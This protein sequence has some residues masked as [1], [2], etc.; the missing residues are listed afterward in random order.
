MPRVGL[1]GAG[2][3][4]QLHLA[5]L[6][7]I[8]GVR[9]VGVADPIR[10]SAERLAA[11][12]NAEAFDDYRQLLGKVDLAWIC[13]PTFL[14]P[15]QT[16]AF[17]EAG[18]HVFCEKPIA[19]DL[20]S[21]DRMI[22]AARGACRQLMIGLVIRYYPETQ[23]IKELLQAGDLGEPVHVFGRRLFSR[24]LALSNDWRRDLQR[25]GGM[26]LES[27]IH[28]IDT[29]RWLGGE[30]TS[31]AGRVVYGDPE[32][33]GYDTDFR[34]LFGL[35]SGATGAVEVSTQVHQRDWSWGVVGTAATA[36]SP[37]RGEVQ[38]IRSGERRGETVTRTIPVD[39]V[40]DFT[41]NVNGGMLS[42]NQAFVEAIQNGQPVPI[43][44]E[45]G[46][47]DLELV[48]AVKDFSARTAEGHK[49]R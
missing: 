23:L 6:M 5:T 10:G 35:A 48:L 9:V 36:T 27:G 20:E 8:D 25:S 28:E 32:Y 14:H 26:T 29:V 3:I 4:G 42:E 2:G 17:A 45:E 44:G 30:V 19:L 18:A 49:A 33:P 38:I 15:E 40:F 13:T 34:A 16:I 12:A 47:R 43:P 41:R 24:G 1:V 39:P 31:V 37:R 11:Q 7:Q 46:R 21:A 22:A